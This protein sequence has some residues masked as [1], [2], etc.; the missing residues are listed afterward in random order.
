MIC[1][2]VKF[3]VRAGSSRDDVLAD[4]R[5]VAE[6]WRGE[7]DLV[8]KHFLFDGAGETIGL[9]LWKNKEAAVAAHDETW[10]R[11]IREAHGSDPS[12][13]YYDTLMIVDNE[14]GTVT[15]YEGGQGAR[16]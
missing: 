12:I 1:E 3:Q 9:Y 16:D 4:A 15:E 13:S 5:S 6:R 14:A 8:R 2:I 11:R 10:R 7:A